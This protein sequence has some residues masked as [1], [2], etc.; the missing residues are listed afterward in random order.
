[1]LLLKQRSHS[2]DS[3]LNIFDK[4][5]PWAKLVMLNICQKVVKSR[6]CKGSKPL[7]PQKMWAGHTNNF[8][9]LAGDVKCSRWLLL[10]VIVK[11]KWWESAW[12][13]STDTLI[14]C[15]T[16]SAW[17]D[18]SLT[19]DFLSKGGRLN[20]DVSLTSEF[21]SERGK[22]NCNVSLTSELEHYNLREVVWARQIIP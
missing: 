6:F 1:M 8:V 17:C 14:E 15:G 10:K 4:C 21:L 9:S 2:L 13:P 12:S 11:G 18:V 22:L 16:Q 7:V 5:P 19:S 20:C 3:C